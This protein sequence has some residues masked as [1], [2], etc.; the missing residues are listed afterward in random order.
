MANNYQRYNNNN[1]SDWR[2]YGLTWEQCQSLIL[3]I[4]VI[5]II[6]I[7]QWLFSFV[8]VPSDFEE[9][10]KNRRHQRL[11]RQSALSQQKKNSLGHQ[12]Q[13]SSLSSSHNNIANTNI[14]NNTSVIDDTTTDPTKEE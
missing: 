8:T 3:A 4:V 10:E 12:Q 9:Q 13:S 14:N 1:Y 11:L 5:G 7:P 6:V 2:F